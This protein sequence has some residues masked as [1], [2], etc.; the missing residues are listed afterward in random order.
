MLNLQSIAVIIREENICK[1]W[2]IDEEQNV[3]FLY[4]EYFDICL[5]RQGDKL[6][7]IFKKKIKHFK[8][9][10][11]LLLNE[12]IPRE[13]IF[14]RGDIFYIQNEYSTFSIDII[15][16]Y[17]DLY[18]EMVDYLKKLKDHKK[19]NIKYNYKNINYMKNKWSN[20]FNLETDQISN[21][22]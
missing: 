13:E 14:I 4:F 12:N 10:L 9:E 16:Y 5:I 11:K 17:F 6:Y 8:K 15:F 1:N 22:Q 2:N 21:S 3:L 18:D 19:N 7:S 20:Y